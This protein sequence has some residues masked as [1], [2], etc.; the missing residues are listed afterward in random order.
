MRKTLLAT[1]ALAA[2]LGFGATAQE[3]PEPAAPAAPAEVMPADPAADPAAP[4]VPEA[5]TAADPMPEATPDVDTAQDPAPA[6]AAPGM[7]TDPALT[8]A[9]P[10]LTP[11]EAG[12]ISA[13]TLIGASI[14]TPDG[15]NIAQVEDVLVSADGAVENVVAQFGGF[16]GFGSNK[17][18]LTLDEIDVMQDEAGNY[19]VQTA[20]TPESLEG[21]PEYQ[22][23]N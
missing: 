8:D 5:D 4:A 20:L 19:V 7:A 21:R 9:A 13:D 2:L 14:Q 16:L 15:Q 10:V 1:T 12:D 18:L 17:V 11:V 3:A 6:P 22:A 23:E